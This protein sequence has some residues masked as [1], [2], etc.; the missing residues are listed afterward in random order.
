MSKENQK[1]PGL[2][3][4]FKALVNNFV[5]VL[6]NLSSLL[7]TLNGLKQGELILQQEKV[8]MATQTVSGLDLR[9]LFA[10]PQAV[11]SL[12]ADT[13]QDDDVNNV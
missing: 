7:Y 11:K 9:T 6:S 13:E 4:L 3:T 5:V 2:W 12:H 1:L 8:M 10:K